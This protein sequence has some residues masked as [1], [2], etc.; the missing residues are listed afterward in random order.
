MKKITI[1][2]V[3]LALIGSSLLFVYQPQKNS[4]SEIDRFS[5]WKPFIPASRLFKA[6]LP[7]KP[8]YGKDAIAIPNSDKM[9]RFD[10]YASE[11]IDGSLFLISMIT[12]PP[13]INVSQDA[14]EI[15]QKNVEEIVANKPGNRLSKMNKGVFKAFKALDFDFENQKYQVSGKAFVNGNIVYILTYST[16]DKKVDPE[17]FNYFIDSFQLNDGVPQ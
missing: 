13:E 11:N 1:V 3:C 17:E 6:S 4:Q 7:Y 8:Q 16:I 15:L 5:T 10:M 14:D 12:Y 2:L 9:R